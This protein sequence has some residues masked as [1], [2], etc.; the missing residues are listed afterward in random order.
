VDSE[1]RLGH[2][3]MNAQ[4]IIT[5][6]HNGLSEWLYESLCLLFAHDGITCERFVGPLEENRSLIPVG[7]HSPEGHLTA[8]E[9]LEG[10]V[11]AIQEE[12]KEIKD[13]MGKVISFLHE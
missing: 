3:L 11:E 13:M 1:N 12:M 5:S 2:Q 8:M 10:K 9:R 6:Q 4:N 7:F